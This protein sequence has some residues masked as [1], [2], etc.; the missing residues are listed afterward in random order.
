[1]A[2]GAF[3]VTVQGP[4][5]NVT[6]EVSEGLALRIVSLA[7]GSG[8]ESA[9]PERSATTESSTSPNAVAPAQSGQEAT[10]ESVGEFMSELN[11]NGNS[12]RIAAIALYLR[13]TKGQPQVTKEELPEWFQRAGEVAPGNLTRDLK[14]AISDKLL[15]EDTNT[16]DSYYVTSTG[17]NKLRNSGQ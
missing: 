1:M 6:R 10:P 11:I 12:E 15:A 13:D 8:S 3:K 14:K 9:A 2:D 16:E 4:D 7:I 5:I 17:V